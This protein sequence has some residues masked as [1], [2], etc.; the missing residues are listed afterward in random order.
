MNEIFS[1][2]DQASSVRVPKYDI[3]L[4]PD[5][6]GKAAAAYRQ[7]TQLLYNLTMAPEAV[8]RFRFR[9]LTYQLPRAAIASVESVA[10]TLNRGPA[11]IA[12]GTDQFL[13]WLQ[14]SGESDASYAG[15]RCKLRPGDV[16]I[17][18]YA[19]EIFV[20]APDFASIYV[21]IERKMVPPVFLEPS[22]HGTHFA[23]DSGAGRILY[24]AVEALFQ[25]LDAL[26]VAEANAALEALI[27]MTAGMLES[28]LAR[29][30]TRDSSGD[31]L[32]DKALAFIDRNL[33]RSDLAPALL[34]KSLPL[35][36]SSLY[37][38]FEPLG[39]V[40]NAIL[41]RRLERAMRALLTGTAAR[42]PL[43]AIARDHGFSSEEQYSRA[44]R[45]RFGMT[46]Y[47]FY[48]MVRRKDTAALAAQVE[49][50]DFP[51]LLKWIKERMD[52]EP[53][54]IR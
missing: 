47:Q 10:Q 36:R 31:L 17:L 54:R 43:R 29:Q 52:S 19:R 25:T 2:S 18:D 35:S 3:Q 46:P 42:P 4:G 20:R 11:E 34:E 40:R 9:S 30:A 48:D 21:M 41:Q 45:T 50:F 53:D 6:D 12:R 37:R 24:R 5:T 33:A 14:V 22:M 16:V 1:A 28:E 49:R 51:G 26:T 15:R 32:L 7:F 39:G 13:I 38:L 44:F 23:A 27:T 8:A